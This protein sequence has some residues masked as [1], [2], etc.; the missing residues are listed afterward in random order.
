MVIVD[1]YSRF[2]V[3]ETTRSLVNEKK[4]PIIDNI[5]FNVRLPNRDENR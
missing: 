3:V 4:I 2:P 5:F 1:G